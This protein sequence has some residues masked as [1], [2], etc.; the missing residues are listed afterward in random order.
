MITR[1][2]ALEKSMQVA[3]EAYGDMTAYEVVVEE[4]ETYW[5]INFTHPQTLTRGGR[6]HFAVWIDKQ[7]AAVKLFRGR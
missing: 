1:E 2:D 4:D 7:T 3:E 5:R 6:Q